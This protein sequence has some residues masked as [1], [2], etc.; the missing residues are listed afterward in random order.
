M[1]DGQKE[2]RGE[3][4]Q[5]TRSH[6]IEPS[7]DRVLSG[8]GDVHQKM[9]EEAWRNRL[10]PCSSTCRHPSAS[11]IMGASAK[12]LFGRSSKKKKKNVLF[13]VAAL[14]CFATLLKWL[15]GSNR[16][17]LVGQSHCS[18]WRVKAISAARRSPEHTHRDW[19][20]GG[21]ESESAFSRWRSQIR[22]MLGGLETSGPFSRTRHNGNLPLAC[23]LSCAHKGG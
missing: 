19:T 16:V 3:T 21:S 7:T 18:Q 22:G 5:I 9:S 15:V 8:A 17:N 23:L 4:N 10:G 1:G 14:L 20:K 12:Q 2:K 11:P 13:N 6:R